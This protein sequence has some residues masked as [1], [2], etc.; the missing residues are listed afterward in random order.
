[1]DVVIVAT[2]VS[3]PTSG[4]KQIQGMGCMADLFVTLGLG[5]ALGEKGEAAWSLS[6]EVLALNQHGRQVG[7]RAEVWLRQTVFGL[8]RAKAMERRVSS[9]QNVHRRLLLFPRA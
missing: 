1:M 9:W 5:R 4:L 2:C 7:G 3:E 8:A 6:R